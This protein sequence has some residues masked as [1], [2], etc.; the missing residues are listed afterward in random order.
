MTDMPL[1]MI[2]GEDEYD[3]SAEPAPLLRLKCDACRFK[4]RLSTR[5]AGIERIS[6]MPCILYRTVAKW[7]V[8]E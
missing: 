3:L 8:S 4:C 7:E 1:Q 2:C 5:T 6:D